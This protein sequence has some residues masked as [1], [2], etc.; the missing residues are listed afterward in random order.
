MKTLPM[1]ALAV[2]VI[3]AACS[4]ARHPVD[5]EPVLLRFRS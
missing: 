5:P 1:L 2:L 4:D 3:A